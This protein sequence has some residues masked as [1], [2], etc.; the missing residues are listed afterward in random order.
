M[1]NPKNLGMSLSLAALMLA[2]TVLAE[3]P[4]GG[5]EPHGGGAPHGAG[6]RTGAGRRMVRLRAA[7][8]MKARADTR[9]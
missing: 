7:R 1:I 6:R 9:G 4:H 5:G 8:R 3:P 2:G